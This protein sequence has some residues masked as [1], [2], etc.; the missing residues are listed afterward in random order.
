LLQNKIN[1]GICD[2]VWVA[3][4]ILILPP[5]CFGGGLLIKAFA[6]TVFNKL[7]ETLISACF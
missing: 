2:F 5:L 6:T 4:L 1:V 3:K 7:V